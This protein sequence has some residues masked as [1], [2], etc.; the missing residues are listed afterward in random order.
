MKEEEKEEEEGL[1]GEEQTGREV[2]GGEEG[3]GRGREKKRRRRTWE[4][5]RRLMSPFESTKKELIIM[6]GR[7]S[8]KTPTKT[9]IAHGS[10][11]RAY[12]YTSKYK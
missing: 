3:G 12:E 8:E 9:R 11:H 4:R 7:R 6:L 1:R 10:S 5:S 2:E